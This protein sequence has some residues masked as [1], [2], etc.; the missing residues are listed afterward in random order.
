MISFDQDTDS[1]R[2]KNR[3]KPVHQVDI[4][5]TLEV[6]IIKIKSKS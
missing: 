1:Y 4:I 3:V 6:T 2:P 5:K